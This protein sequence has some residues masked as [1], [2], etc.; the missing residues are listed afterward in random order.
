[1]RDER[2]EA[3]PLAERFKLDNLIDDLAE[4]LRALR[5]GRISVR[6]ARARADL[7]KQILRGVHYVVIAQK[8]MAERALPVPDSPPT[9][10]RKR[11]RS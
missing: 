2:L 1:M 5:A 6:D 9:P 7:A 10:P 3:A 11:G 8:F 4:D